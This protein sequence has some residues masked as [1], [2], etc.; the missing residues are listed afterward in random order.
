MLSP[1]R[2]IKSRKSWISKKRHFST[3]RPPSRPIFGNLAKYQ[4]NVEKSII[5]FKNLRISCWVPG[6]QLNQG[7]PEFQRN[8]IFRHV[9]RLA[10]RF[11]EIWQSIKKI[12]KNRSYTLKILEFHVESPEGNKIKEIPNFKE[13]S[14]FDMSSAQPDRFRA[15]FNCFRIVFGPFSD[16]F[17]PFRTVFAP[18]FFR[19]FAS[20]RRR[21]KRKKQTKL[22][23]PSRRLT[24]PPP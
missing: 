2:A 18:F 13:T 17:G 7:N 24:W 1:R 15:V 10:G 22:W 3:F 23:I 9:V 8:D 21:R 6:G 4:K 20:W 19:F 12:S 11:S 16:R 5:H 14:F